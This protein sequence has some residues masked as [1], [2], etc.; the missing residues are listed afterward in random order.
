MRL[1]LRWLTLEGLKVVLILALFVWIQGHLV[2]TKHE[3]LAK[4]SNIRRYQEKQDHRLEALEDDLGVSGAA[5]QETVREVQHV[6]DRLVLGEERLAS[7]RD[8]IVRLI[9]DKAGELR[10]LLESGI[11]RVEGTSHT[12]FK[13]AR[14]TVEKYESLASQ[15]ER[16]PSEMKQRMI[17]PVVQLRGNGTVGSGVVIASHESE[18]EAALVYVLT[19]YHVVLEILSDPEDKQVDDLRF[20]DPKTDRLLEETHNAQLVAYHEAADVALLTVLLDEPWPFTAKAAS[21][22]GVRDL[23]IFDQVYA[24]GCPLGNKPLPTAGEI[25]SQE[26]IVGGQNFWMVNAPTFFGNSGGGVF[27]AETGELIGISSM[28]YT[29]GKSQPMVVPHMGLFVPLDMIREWLTD[30]GYGHLIGKAPETTTAAEAAASPESA[31]AVSAPE[32]P[33]ESDAAGG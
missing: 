33:S 11:L 29:Y 20:L 14:E 13:Q 19:A 24:V 4:T 3:V 10:S 27:Q 32:T 22:D 2:D 21:Y 9:D 5:M 8:N 31:A 17:Y 26:K 30:E 28:I 23:Q 16:S 7:E 12:A 6:R 25:S 15:I 1:T 18:E